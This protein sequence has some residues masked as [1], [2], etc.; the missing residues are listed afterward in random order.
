MGFYKAFLHF[1]CNIC[2]LSKLLA[3]ILITQTEKFVGKMGK[4]KNLKNPII[5]QKFVLD[6]RLMNTLRVNVTDYKQTPRG[7]SSGKT[8]RNP[9]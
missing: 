8:S 6:D 7:D 9:G 4:N 2:L 3:N 5:K 1:F